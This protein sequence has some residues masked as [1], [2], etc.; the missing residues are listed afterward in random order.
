MKQLRL[1]KGLY[2]Y[3]PKQFEEE[4][5]ILVTFSA[6]SHGQLLS[7]EGLIEDKRHS[8]F[9]YQ[10]CKLAIKSILSI[11]GEEVPFTELSPKSLQDIST[12]ILEMSST[13]QDAMDNL[14]MS[15]NIKFG[16]DFQGETWDCEV[17]QGKR[18]D[19]TRNCGYRGEK[20]LLDDFKI[21][22]D[23]QVYTYC[24]IYD[25]D[26]SVLAD[27]VDSYVMYDKQLLPDSGGLYDQTRFFVLSSSIVKNKLR[28]E[29]HKE[30]KKQERKNK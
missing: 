3:T 29:E 12:T 16:G 27:A 22:A 7:L 20:E 21:I 2:Y 19:R 24:P 1:S 6:L 26:V 10:S 28:E 14:T 9:T 15:V 8:E 23:N 18:L 30:A 11:K 25:V 17:C 5:D 13:P 4:V